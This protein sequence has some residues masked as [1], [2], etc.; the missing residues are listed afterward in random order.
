MVR[1]WL[2]AAGDELPR[3]VRRWLACH[4]AIGALL[5]AE[6]PEAVA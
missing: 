2:E 6:E 5:M 4:E 1:L 3:L